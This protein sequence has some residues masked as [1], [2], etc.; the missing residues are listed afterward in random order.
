M[1]KRLWGALAGVAAYAFLASRPSRVTVTR[2]MDAH[3]TPQA[4]LDL[5]ADVEREPEF[6]PFVTRVDV[7]DRRGEWTRYV[8][9][10]NGAGVTGWM[11]FEKRVR[12]EGADAGEAT[13][14]S[15]GGTLG[16]GQWGRLTVTRRDERIR[17]TARATTRFAA[18]FIG[19]L[20]THASAPFV[21]YAFM[22]W[23]ETMERELQ[24]SSA[25]APMREESASG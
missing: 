10:L 9:R 15:M 21:V 24:A 6:I 3:S 8:V 1:D 23:L 14:R 5:V 19:P 22:K 16:A 13:W 2:E 17:V 11:R 12:A 20:L 25:T 7:E 18:P 4:W